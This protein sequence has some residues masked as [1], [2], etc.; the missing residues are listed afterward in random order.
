MRNFPDAQ[1]VHNACTNLSKTLKMARSKEVLRIDIDGNP[2]VV[3]RFELADPCPDCRL[4]RG[5]FGA[6]DQEPHP[7]ATSDPRNGCSGGAK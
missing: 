4:Q 5:A 7:M 6:F 3:R 1:P 2:D